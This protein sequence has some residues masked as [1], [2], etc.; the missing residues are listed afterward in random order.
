ML[1]DK[2]LK[3]MMKSEF[4]EH[5]EN[6]YPIKTLKALGLVRNICKKCKRGFWTSKPQDFCGDASCREGY[7]FIGKN[8]I[9]K[10]SYKETY[11]LF[12]KTFKKW[13]YVPIKR[14]PVICRWYDQL[15][16]VAAGINDFQPYVVSGQVPPPSQAVT[17]DQFCLRFNDIENVGMT[18]RHYTGFIMIGQH[19]FNTP[20]K[21]LY[22]KEEAVEQLYKFF[23]EVLKIPKDELYLHEDLWAGGGNFGPSIEFF[24]NG[25]ELANQVYMQYEQTETG[26]RELQ[27][28]VI[29][30]GAGAERWAW[31]S[32][33]ESMSYDIVFPKVMNY[34]YSAAKI[35]KNEDI[36]KKFAQYTAFLDVE[37]IENV[38]VE[39]KKIS[40]KIG[41]DPVELRREILPIAAL[42]AIADH[43][44]TLLV[45]VHDGELPSNVGGG[46]N[47]RNI[48]RRCFALADKYQFNID[49]EKVIKL[50]I[51]EFG[52]WYTDLKE[53]CAIF[54]VLKIEY[55]R[56]KETLTKAKKIV[57][58][59][60]ESGELFNTDNLI[61]LY[62]SNGITP[63]VI[64]LIKPDINLPS[65]FYT[66]LE[67]LKR[68]TS[69]SKEV[70]ID[71]VGLPKTEFGF[72]E[73]PDKF[74][75]KAKVIKQI[76]NFL[77]LDKTYFYPKMG[78]QDWDLGTID[79]VPL[80]SVQIFD[81]V[82]A[83]ELSKPA[84]FEVGQE[85]KGE[86]DK[87][88]R[89]QLTISHSAIHLVGMAARQLLGKHINQAGS[90]KTV[91]KSRID[92]T[93]YK[94]LTF[95][96]LQKIEQIA[97]EYIS[98][99]IDVKT[100]IFKREE[101]EQKY[102]MN[103]YQGGAVPGK[104]IRI[105]NI[106]D[107]DIQAC[108]GTHVN[109]T[110]EIKFIK[111]INSEK[112]KDGVVRIEIMVGD[113]ALEKAQESEKILKDIADMW[114]ISINEVPKTAKRFFEEWK[115]QRK[116]LKAISEELSKPLVKIY[117]EAEKNDPVV[118]P[119][120][121][122][123]DSSLIIKLGDEASKQYK[124]RALII[125]GDNFAY[126]YSGNEKVDISS[127]LKKYCDKVEGDSKKAKGFNLKKD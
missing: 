24:S 34:L 35:K 80:K 32:S 124:D 51:E 18:G 19:V 49:F 2:E 3:K 71:I 39:L 95:D 10:I 91:E 20:D 93:H 123:K 111:L 43:T 56:Y 72:R 76:G 85:V 63:E 26:Y 25:L 46:Y 38:D 42:Y 112:V 99:G 15:Y 29:D 62:E 28:K 37:D 102:G 110:K 21:Y 60:Y 14:Y 84:K 104:E 5:F 92:I 22:F 70:P 36:W 57:E 54:E 4:Y 44:R 67:D 55:E 13:G 74:K 41:V 47:L 119:L 77:I 89:K 117:L 50:H 94:A 40:Q 116:E 48:L 88:R 118:I 75:F 107:M 52:E 69:K 6:Y 122:I 27:T 108:G 121:I 7:S 86:V 98:K 87:E 101:A 73:D 126:G 16:F 83:H 61:R 100:N 127:A 45:A 9:P 33:G 106:G 68:P 23:I 81:G 82:I 17:E 97:N 30:M 113:K 1:T 78:G 96:E 53:P 90:E 105:V 11:D 114:S 65:D 64:K 120:N 31:L 125:L 12:V 66:K 58:K 59:M 109:N 8:V 79:D 103:I 115:E